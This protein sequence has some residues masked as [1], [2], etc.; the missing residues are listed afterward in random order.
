MPR[1]LKEERLLSSKDYDRVR[2][3]G[4]RS[5]T[6][7]LL[8]S[9]VP[10][11][12]KRLGIVVTSKVGSAVKRNRIKRVIREHFRTKKLDYPRGD[13]VVVMKAEAGGLCNNE[14]RDYLEQALKRLKAR[15]EEN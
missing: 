8:I 14:I 2:I 13:C 1:F 3:E 4:I 12:R 7:T 15:A 10:R 11:R 9:Y 5:Q 6:K